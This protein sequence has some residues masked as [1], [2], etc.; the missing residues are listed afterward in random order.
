MLLQSSPA[1]PRR[2][3]PLKERIYRSCSTPTMTIVTHDHDLPYPARCYLWR[4]LLELYIGLLFSS[5]K[6]EYLRLA[7]KLS[8]VS[9]WLK[10]P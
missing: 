1:E 5:G 10:M 6:L 3:H 2:P 9:R 7:H 8:H 4:R